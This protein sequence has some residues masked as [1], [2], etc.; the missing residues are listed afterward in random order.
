ML[1]N[2]R[3]VLVTHVDAHFEFFRQWSKS[4]IMSAAE[5][6]KVTGREG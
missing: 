5:G 1:A 2:Q 6:P 3:L 4:D